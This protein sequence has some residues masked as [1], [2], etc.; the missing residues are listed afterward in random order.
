MVAFGGALILFD[1][2]QSYGP[3]CINT[4]LVG[5]MAKTSGAGSGPKEEKD[6]ADDDE[7]DG[8]DDDENS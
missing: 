3:K 8:D 6:D 7:G 2:R 5:W 1:A 4:R